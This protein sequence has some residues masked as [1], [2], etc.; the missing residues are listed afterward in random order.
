MEPM[1]IEKDFLPNVAQVV[2]TASVETKGLSEL[3]KTAAIDVVQ[4]KTGEP[5]KIYDNTDNQ[6]FLCVSYLLDEVVRRVT[7]VPRYK[8][9]GAK[10]KEQP[11]NFYLYCEY[12]EDALTEEIEKPQRDVVMNIFEGFFSLYPFCHGYWMRYVEYEV[13]CFKESTT[14]ASD[15]DRLAKVMWLYEE[16]VQKSRVPRAISS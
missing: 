6:V 16:N 15:E 14:E 9:T 1:K 5:I 8:K 2:A 11:F 12:L 13:G 3:T 7:Y 4:A 10:L